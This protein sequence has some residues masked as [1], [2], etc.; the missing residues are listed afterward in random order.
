ML[1][2]IDKLPI[3]ALAMIALLMALMPLTATPHLWEK[4]VMLSQGELSRPIDIF[5][6]FMH[7]TPLLLLVIRLYRLKK[8]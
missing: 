3:A 2:W 8:Q 5:D 6:M 1:N 7:G 4:L